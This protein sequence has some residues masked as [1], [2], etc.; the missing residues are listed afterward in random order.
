MSSDILMSI[1]GWSATN[2]EFSRSV[3]TQANLHNVWRHTQEITAARL[4]SLW[5][6]GIQLCFCLGLYLIPVHHGS[7]PDMKKA[8]HDPTCVARTG[9]DDPV[10]SDT[11]GHE[12][13]RSSDL[14]EGLVSFITTASTAALLHNE[15][16]NTAAKSNKTR[17]LRS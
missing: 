13:V 2:A 4:L 3:F 8:D 16:G 11:S 9:L 7:S 5:A 15:Q 17:T 6:L 1:A 14:D 12:S 10:V